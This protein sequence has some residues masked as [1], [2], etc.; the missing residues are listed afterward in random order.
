LRI[1]QKWGFGMAPMKPETHARRCR[2]A[3]TVVNLLTSV[4]HVNPLAADDLSEVKGL[5]TRSCKQDQWD[6][7]TVWTQLGRPGKKRCRDISDKLWDLRRATSDRDVE[8]VAWVRHQL[9]IAGAIPV[10]HSFLGLRHVG[11]YV[12]DSIGYIYILSTRSNPRMLKIGYTERTVE[13]RVK[14]INRA[15][16]VLEPYG[17][18]AVWVVNNAQHVERVVH[19]ALANYRIRRDREFFELPYGTAFKLVG[20]IVHQSRRE[21]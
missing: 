17:V 20:D 11:H 13:D 9:I 4:P 21:M 3:A 8:R 7:F 19:E 6:W 18:R 15:T 14:E 10:L 2:A 16:G 5:F 1:H 12:G